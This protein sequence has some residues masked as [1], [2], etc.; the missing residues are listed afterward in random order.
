MRIRNVQDDDAGFAMECAKDFVEYYPVDL[1]WNED[2]MYDFLSNIAT[3][4]VFLIA[5]GEDGERLG[6]IL[7]FITPH[8]YDPSMIMLTEL[9]WWV[10]PEHRNG[11]VGLKL[12]KEFEKA[13]KER[14]CSAISMTST[15][16]TPELPKYFEK[17]GYSH[18]ESNYVRKY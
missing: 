9:A 10:A 6:G 7:G 16:H 14:G 3:N 17:K 5:E 18:V 12:F 2:H 11:T 13:G 15:V 1:A 4:G 8:F